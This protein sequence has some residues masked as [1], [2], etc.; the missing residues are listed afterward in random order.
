[1]SGNQAAFSTMTPAQR[2]VCCCIALDRL[3]SSGFIDPPA[4][5][6]ARSVGAASA[7]LT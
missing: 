5:S 3:K 6:A 7:A 1:M 2:R 4:R